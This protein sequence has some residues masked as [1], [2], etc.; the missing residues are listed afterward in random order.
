MSRRRPHSISAVTTLLYRDGGSVCYFLSL[1][2]GKIK[3]SLFG[4]PLG[5][6][7]DYSQGIY[8]Q[9]RMKYLYSQNMASSTMSLEPPKDMMTNRQV[10]Q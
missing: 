5:N 9:A 1:E 3:H 4:D 6:H 10:S 2:N 8:Y 7:G